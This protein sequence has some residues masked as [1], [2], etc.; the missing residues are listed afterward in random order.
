MVQ[1]EERVPDGRLFAADGWDG[2]NRPLATVD[3]CASP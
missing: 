2:L 3:M 1:K